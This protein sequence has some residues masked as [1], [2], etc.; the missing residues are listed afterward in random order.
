MKQNITQRIVAGGTVTL[1]AL[2]TT[3]CGNAGTEASS[4]TSSALQV[5]AA[6]KEEVNEEITEE[7][8]SLDNVGPFTIRVGVNS[9]DGN[10][11]LKILDDHTSFLKDRGIDLQ[12]TE[13][14][15]G[16]NTID[17]I[18]TG[19]LDVGLFADYAGVNRIGNTLKDTELRAFAMINK[20]NN[21]HLYVNPETIKEPKDLEGAT[22]VSMAGVVFEY[23]YGKLFETYDID[24]SKVNIVNVSSAQE[25][26]A[27]AAS[28]GA[29]SYWANV[30]VAPKFE[31]AG[32][33]PLLSIGD[34]N[35]TMYTFL[36]ANQSYL[37]EHKAEVAKYLA[38][39]E[40]AFAYIEENLDE[41][42]GWVETDLGL[43]KDL[44]I[45]GWNAVNHVY[46]FPQDAYEDLISV[47]KWCYNN[48][49]F[50]TDYDFTG[51]INTNALSL[52]DPDKVT[53]QP[54]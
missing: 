10:Q 18:T 19:Q 31:E 7:N 34:V 35:A 44:V 45:S 28:N 22:A 5:N 14:A 24:K 1:L 47:E 32:W 17:A 2:L 9:G 30:Q 13:F 33:T 6:D 52:V 11:Y 46:T 27:L 53:W 39:S 49:N 38:V 8:F 16:I 26:L 43:K 48:G 29:D 23:D 4:A 37:D 36:V 42:A 21:Y 41:F 3:G 15:A 50:P 20:T 12:T 51:F 25:A 54:K 40:E